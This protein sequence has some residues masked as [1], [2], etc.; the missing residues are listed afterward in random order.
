[1]KKSTIT[2]GIIAGAVMAVISLVSFSAWGKSM[3]FDLGEIVGY[4]SM[5]LSLLAVFLG[6]RHYRDKHNNGA[7]QFKEGFKIGLSITVVAGVVFAIYVYFFYTEVAPDF[8]VRYQEF[9]VEKIQKSKLPAQEKKQQIDQL[10]KAMH[11]PL[12]SNWFFQS[13]LMFATVF[14]IGL[15]I[16]II[17]AFMLKRP[18]IAANEGKNQA[19]EKEK[20]SEDK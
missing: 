19:R 10:K 1:M 12:Y 7:L 3:D 9:Y 17:A 5:I 14:L 15:L 13:F 16:T 11:D 18:A 4:S 20:V 2:Y 8:M 6:I